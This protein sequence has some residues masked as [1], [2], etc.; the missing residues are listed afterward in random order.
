[1]RGFRIAALVVAAVLVCLV[2]WRVLT[3]DPPREVN[4]DA[5]LD[6]HPEGPVN[7]PAP[8]PVA[9]AKAAQPAKRKKA[10]PERIA[11]AQPPAVTV[12]EETVSGDS[13][14]P[15]GPKATIWRGNDPVAAA[16]DQSESAPVQTASVE[17]SKGPIIVTPYQRPKEDNRG[18]RWMKA[19]GHALGIGGKPSLEDQ[20]FR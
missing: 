13:E 10:A 11:E 18:V 4:T 16:D 14:A 3:V 2:A 5:I 1:M 6:S 15:S 7:V 17:E 19:V 9:G 8:P 12:T 20:A